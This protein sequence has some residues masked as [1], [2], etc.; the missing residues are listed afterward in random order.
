MTFWPEIRQ[1]LNESQPAQYDEGGVLCQCCP[2]F[3][4]LRRGGRYIANAQDVEVLKLTVRPCNTHKT[5]SFDF[6]LL[7]SYHLPVDGEDILG[8]DWSVFDT[9]T[10]PPN[11]PG[12]EFYDIDVASV[13]DAAGDRPVA[14]VF[15]IDVDYENQ[16]Y[17]TTHDCDFQ[18]SYRII[19][20]TCTDAEPDPEQYICK[21]CL[22]VDG[23]KVVISGETL[24]ERRERIM[25]YGH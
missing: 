3:L 22:E 24:A 17:P 11:T 14:F 23:E 25:L 15:V 12:S 4:E 18:C 9:Y 6:R 2:P 7:Y 20:I 21:N 13:L 16:S 19:D 5:R 10:I 8:S 1:R